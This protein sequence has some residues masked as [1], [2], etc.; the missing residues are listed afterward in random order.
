MSRAFSPR[1]VLGLVLFGAIAFVATLWLIGAGKTDSGPDNGE[2]HAAGHG[3]AGYSALVEMLQKQ[4]QDVS[5]SRNQARLEDQALLV[6]TPTLWTTADDLKAVIDRRRYTGPTLVILPKWYAVR[7]P[8]LTAGARK[9]WV[10]LVATSVP[11]FADDLEGELKMKPKVARLEG[12]TAD[13]HGLGLSGTLPDRGH[14]LGLEDGPWASL[15]RDSKGRDLVAYA[16]DHGCYPVL[17]DA[18]GYN[19]PTGDDCEKD[20]WNVTFVFEP[21][22]FNNY[23]L[24]DRERALLAARV[25]D[26][27]REGQ[28]IPVVFDLT[29]AGLGGAKNLLTLAFAPPFLAAT[30]CLLIALVV[31]GWRGFGRFGPALAE[32]R[33]I[34]FGKARLAANAGGFVRRSGRLHLLGPPY[35]A[36]AAR[37]IARALG[38]RGAD[39]GAIDAAIARRDP[40]APPF[41]VL[42]HRLETARGANATLRAAHALHA[43]ERDLTA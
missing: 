31:V 14:A 4:G 28:D 11:G 38:L 20:K 30:L 17:D 33:A 3:L 5:L 32:T 1:T 23:G 24:A 12:A 2:A 40:S 13:W 15:V 22:L 35:A 27:A 7:V 19:S 9:G 39:P 25:I 10:Q 16:D 42:A 37:R 36:M 43:F 41:S 8:P 26:L 29:L 18:A 6:L 34:A 21:D